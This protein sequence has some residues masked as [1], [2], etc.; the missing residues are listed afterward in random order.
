M[1]LLAIEIV[2]AILQGGQPAGLMM[3]RD[4][5]QR[6]GAILWRQWLPDAEAAL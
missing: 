3:A 5:S 6:I 1:T 2:E 4:A